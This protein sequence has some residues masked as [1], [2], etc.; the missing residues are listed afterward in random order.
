MTTPVPQ[1]P[2]NRLHTGPSALHMI[3][4]A[5]RSAIVRLGGRRCS[6]R[7]DRQYPRFLLLEPAEDYEARREPFLGRYL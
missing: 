3:V 6:R 4:A 7:R 2:I 5:A 1:T